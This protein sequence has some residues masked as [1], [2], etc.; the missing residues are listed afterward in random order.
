[1]QISDLIMTYAV[2]Y[3]ILLFSCCVHEVAHAWTANA[4]GDDTA[5][6][7]GRITLNP[8]VHIDPI[9]TVLFPL[10]ALFAGGLWGGRVL[11]FGWAKP[12]PVNPTRFHNYRRDDIIVS[13]AGITSNLLLALFAASTLRTLNEFGGFFQGSSILHVTR[14]LLYEL[15]IINVVLG[16]FN[17]I[18]IPPLD[19]SRVLYHYLPMQ[20]AWEFRKLEQFGFVILILFFYTGVFQTIISVPLSIFM[21]IAGRPGF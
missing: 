18:P 19:G 5:K 17:L 14:V 3:A 12:V 4:C 15:M 21:I 16:V 1:M 8:A 13:L 7:M 10:L 11:L 20:L 6:L 2:T 9:G